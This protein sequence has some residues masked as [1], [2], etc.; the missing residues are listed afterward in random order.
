MEIKFPFQAIGLILDIARL[1]DAQS[2][3]IN[4]AESINKFSFLTFQ[5]DGKPLKREQFVSIISHSHSN[6]P[7]T[8]EISDKLKFGGQRLGKTIVFITISDEMRR[9]F[10]FSSDSLVISHYDQLY[11]YYAYEERISDKWISTYEGVMHHKFIINTLKNY[12]ENPEA[13]LYSVTN[14]AILIFENNLLMSAD[15][16]YYTELVTGLGD[17]QQCKNTKK[18][19]FLSNVGFELMH[20]P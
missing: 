3:S 4:S 17:I 7:I 6:D 11:S 20:D 2:I 8:R 18:V 16:I 13:T 10:M 9:V 19:E 15:K 12:L 5:F 14:H 1:L